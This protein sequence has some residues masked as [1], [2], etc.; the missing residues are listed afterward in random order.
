[1]DSEELVTSVGRS[2]RRHGEREWVGTE[3]ERRR[4]E[5]LGKE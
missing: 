1:M 4:E 3:L 5:G 2:R